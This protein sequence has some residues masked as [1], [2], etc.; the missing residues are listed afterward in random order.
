MAQTSSLH[1]S[2][3]TQAQ[4]G[5]GE[6]AMP[7]EPIEGMSEL[8]DV[9]DNT[10]EYGEE[11]D[12][13]ENSEIQED[14]D[15]VD[16]DQLGLDEEEEESTEEEVTTEEETPEVTDTEEEETPQVQTPEENAFYAEQRRQQQEAQRQREFEEQY[17][18]KAQE[19]PEYKVAQLLAAQYGV[20]VEQMLQQLEDSQLEQQAQSQGV[21][22]EFLRQQQEQQRQMETLQAQL[23]EMEFKNWMAKQDAEAEALK[24]EY[25]FLTDADINEARHFMLNDL[26]TTN[27]NLSDA[28]FAKHQPKIISHLKAQAKQEALAE[29]SGRKPNGT[30]PNVS[31]SSPE[32]ELSMEEKAMARNLGM[33]EE[34]YL[35]YK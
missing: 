5:R 31:Q 21:P 26:Q 10:N 15:I 17:M 9:P 14:D 27:M 28:V 13:T 35:K 34:D 33:S 20:P 2:F 29:I 23:K 7:T 11:I 30:A 6:L 32:S 18:Q 16:V 4:K 24:K 1:K 12:V 3:A 19:S 25:S 22:V 8:Y